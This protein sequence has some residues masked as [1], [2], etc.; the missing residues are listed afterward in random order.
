M[1]KP[2]LSL[3]VAVL[4]PA[5]LVPTLTAEKWGPK[6]FGSEWFAHYGG[7]ATMA[8]GVVMTIAVAAILIIPNL[9]P[10]F[11]FFGGSPTERRI[12]KTGR[13]A[14]A[15]VVAVGENSGGGAVTI[16]DQPYLNLVVRV[17]DG[18]TAPYEASFDAIIPRAQVPQVQP[19]AILAVKV[20]PQNPKRVVLDY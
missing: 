1:A 2:R 19:G 15:T 8:Y 10:M 14:R 18:V 13:P 4:V 5:T 16:N 6:V 11:S 3:W 9:G 20:D 17:E 7:P 12:R